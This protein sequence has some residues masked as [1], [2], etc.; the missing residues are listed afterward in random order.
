MRLLLKYGS[1]A[2]AK[3]KHEEDGTGEII[4]VGQYIVNEIKQD[5]LEFTDPVLKKIFDDYSFNRI[6]LC[7]SPLALSPYANRFVY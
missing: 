5:E 7:R 1:E 6:V 4:L 3:V 2:Y